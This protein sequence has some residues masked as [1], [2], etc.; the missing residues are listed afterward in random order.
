MFLVVVYV[1]YIFY[2]EEGEGG[3]SAADDV[4]KR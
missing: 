4:I 1:T 3:M 2:G